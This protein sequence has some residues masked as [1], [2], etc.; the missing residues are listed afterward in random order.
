MNRTAEQAPSGC[1]APDLSRRATWPATIKSFGIAFVAGLLLAPIPFFGAL[2][3]APEGFIL[4]ACLFFAPAFMA[5]GIAEAGGASHNA[6]I[7][8]AFALSLPLYG[9]YSLAIT[10]GRRA[11]R[12]PLIFCI[13]VFLHYLA[14]L[15]A[16]WEWPRSEVNLDI[17]RHPPRSWACY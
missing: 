17:I 10:A 7:V 8:I 2:S 6:Q 11:H 4:P 16:P 5:V 3:I 15:F 13:I 12:G 1:E 14:F 9:V